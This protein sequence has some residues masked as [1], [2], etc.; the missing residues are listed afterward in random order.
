M[1]SNT[2][3]VT[4]VTESGSEPGT[5][6]F[7]KAYFIKVLDVK[8]NWGWN[9]H[10]SDFTDV[11]FTSE[12]DTQAEIRRL[13][14]EMKHFVE[15]KKD[16]K[17]ADTTQKRIAALK[18]SLVKRISLRM[19]QP[20]L[21]NWRSF[22]AALDELLAKWHAKIDLHK[23]LSGTDNQAILLLSEEESLREELEGA[24]FFKT[25]KYDDALQGW[26]CDDV[27]DSDNGSACRSSRL[28]PT[29]GADCAIAVSDH[30]DND[31]YVIESDD[32]LVETLKSYR[33]VCPGD[34]MYWHSRSVL[35]HPVP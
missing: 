22:P 34:E 14:E 25:W 8:E 26:C 29:S 3:G 27:F 6:A 1:D 12:A 5:M 28:R 21:L 18:A 16:Y 10:N 19:S 24:G 7:V 32:V 13:E 20:G 11:P 33:P 30:V 35:C 15:V 9:W 2:G 23:L 4:R 17:Q 31:D